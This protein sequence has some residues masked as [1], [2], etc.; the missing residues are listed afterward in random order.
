[1]DVLTMKSEEYKR[2]PS[3]LKNYA[4]HLKVITGNSEKTICEYL[5]DLRT[6]FRFYIMIKN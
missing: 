4:S 5:M 6:F 1:M 3:V 2:F